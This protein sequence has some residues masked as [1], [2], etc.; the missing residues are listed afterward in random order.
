MKESLASAALDRLLERS[1]NNRL[2]PIP[3]RQSPSVS[4]VIPHYNY[5]QYLAIAVRSA[6][7][8]SGVDIEVLIVDDASTDG[9]VEVAREVAGSDPRVH[10]IEHQQNMRHIATYNDGLERATGKYVVLLSADD[11]L[12]P[13]C[14]QRATAL[15]EAYP[16]VGL[17]YGY[18]GLFS[19]SAP[20]QDEGPAVLN[21]DRITW[22]K[23]RGQEWISYFCRRGRNLIRNPEAIMRRE[24]GE[25]LG[26][27]DANF[28]HSADMYLWMRAA[29]RTEVGRING[30]TQAYY[31]LHD[32]NMHTTSFGG[33]LD[34]YREVR[35]TFDQF[36][37]FESGNFSD[38]TRLRAMARRSVS[39][40]AVRRSV[41]LARPDEH[42]LREQL[43][44]F[45]AETDPSD[46]AVRA[47]HR[48]ITKLGLTPVLRR[49]EKIRWKWRYR[50]QVTVGT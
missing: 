4:V 21:G 1:C 42:D 32:T 31:R 44:M 28:P 41:F 3:P 37:E 47:V 12:A 2:S 39:R 24:L 9:S 13:G 14:L 6:L 43:L 25:A 5:G 29:A 7:E 27:Y 19:D 8:Q 40:E 10:L 11:L 34:D 49:A 15:M 26:W 48:F 33:L 30:V 38:P 50:R 46:K 20:A 17:V 36:F 16:S 45:A 22:T 35:N 18:A 23:W